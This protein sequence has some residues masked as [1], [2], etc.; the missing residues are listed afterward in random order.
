MFTFCQQKGKKV[1][2]SEKFL[3]FMKI[4]SFFCASKL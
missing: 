2:Q 3:D 4:K 1:D